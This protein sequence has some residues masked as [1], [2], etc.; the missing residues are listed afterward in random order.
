MNKTRKWAWALLG[1]GGLLLAIVSIR[2]VQS[3]PDEKPA[4]PET[5]VDSEIQDDDHYVDEETTPSAGATPPGARN[6]PPIEIT[7]EGFKPKTQ[8]RGEGI[9]APRDTPHLRMQE[10]QGLDKIPG[11]K[12]AW[13]TGIS[14]PNPSPE[15]PVKV[16]GN[17]LRKTIGERAPDAD[18]NDAPPPPPEGESDFAEPPADNF[19]QDFG[20]GSGN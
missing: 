9:P 17:R 10:P 15:I 16:G 4:A 20:G 11:Q 1:V 8:V 7:R 13:N 6:M 12:Q 18:F 5:V 19:Q 2:M 3:P 14:N